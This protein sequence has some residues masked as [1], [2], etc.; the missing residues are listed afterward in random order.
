MT[1][2]YKFVLFTQ[3]IG[4]A[5]KAWSKTFPLNDHKAMR[6]NNAPKINVL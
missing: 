6:E 2:P 1:T 5:H 4:P 3:D